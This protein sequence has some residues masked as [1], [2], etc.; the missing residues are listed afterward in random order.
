MLFSKTPL[1]LRECASCP[2]SP[3]TSMLDELCFGFCEIISTKETEQRSM[4]NVLSTLK[5]G[6]GGPVIKTSRKCDPLLF[7]EIISV[8]STPTAPAA[9]K[10][11]GSAW[12]Q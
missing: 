5:C 2:P 1:R 8:T 10:T 4:G 6:G 3:H 7:C 12:T 9:A 11:S